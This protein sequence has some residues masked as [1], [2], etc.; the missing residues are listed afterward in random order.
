MWTKLGQWAVGKLW[1]KLVPHTLVV[2][3]LYRI[4][5]IRTFFGT[6]AIS[7]EKLEDLGF[8]RHGEGGKNE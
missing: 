1:P 3:D 2:D 5:T 4:L 8:K 7:Y 6:V